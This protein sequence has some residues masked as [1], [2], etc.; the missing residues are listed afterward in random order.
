MD[1]TVDKNKDIE[2]VHSIE[3]DISLEDLDYQEDFPVRLINICKEANLTS[4]KRIL[5]FYEREKSFLSLPNCGVL[6]DKKL[7]ELCK[8]HLYRNPVVEIDDSTNK[9]NKVKANTRGKYNLTKKKKEPRIKLFVERRG[10]KKKADPVEPVTIYIENSII[11]NNQGV[12]L[13]RTSDAFKSKLGEFKK[14]LQ[15]YVYTELVDF[16]SQ[17]FVKTAQSKETHK[18]QEN[19]DLKQGNKMTINEFDQEIEKIEIKHSDFFLSINKKLKDCILKQFDEDGSFNYLPDLSIDKDNEK[20]K[21]IE[22][23]LNKLRLKK[24]TT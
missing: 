1:D 9:T 21:L 8:K 7:S 12:V 11:T 20:W 13:D 15:L 22:I 5:D 14:K 24:I 6:I 17:Y 18:E 10:R 23:D 3:D 19:L 4:L 2:I 16:N